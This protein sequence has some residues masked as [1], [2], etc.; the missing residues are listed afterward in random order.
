M[1]LIR[2]VTTGWAKRI[3]L[4][5]SLALQAATHVRPAQIKL[6]VAITLNDISTQ[7]D[8]DAKL[9]K[10]FDSIKIVLPSND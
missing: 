7:L 2:E 6:S 3:R 10:Q 4:E 8:A 5:N 1:S 9:K